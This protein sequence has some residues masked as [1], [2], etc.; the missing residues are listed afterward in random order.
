VAEI[1]EKQAEFYNNRINSNVMAGDQ[2]GVIQAGK[3][4]DFKTLGLPVGI[5]AAN[6]ATFEVIDGVGFLP[7]EG[8][9][10]P[11]S[12]IFS[13]LFGGFAGLDI[14]TRDFK[15]MLGRSDIHTIV[16]EIDSPGGSA[17]G[18]QQ[19]A[20][21]IF[22]SRSVKPIISVTSGT[23]ASA[24]MWIGAA[25]H[26]VL[27]TGDV[28]VVGSIGTVTTHTDISEFNKMMGIKQTEVAAGEFKRVPSSLEPLSEK[29]REVLQDQVNRVN[30][31]FVNGIASF[32]GVPVNT[33]NKKMGNGKIF[34][35]TQAIDAG[36][37]DE[38][39]TVESF[40]G[41][42]TDSA[43]SLRF[44]NKK[45]SNFNIFLGGAKMTVMEQLAKL[46]EENVDLYN[47]IIERGKAIAKASLDQDLAD[48]KAAEY[49]R[50]VED[51]KLEGKNDGAV[52]ERE[53]ITSI[54]SFATSSNMAMIEGFIADGKTTAPEAAVEILKAQKESNANHLQ[55]LENNAPKPIGADIV[56]PD[57]VDGSEKGLKQLVA[58]YMADNKGVTK[59]KA[60]IAC[61][62]LYPNA[63]N[64]FVQEVKKSA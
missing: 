44:I 26:K 52:A 38:K 12:D 19:F 18:I 5:N 30:D 40:L 20:N 2:K 1:Y 4:A 3:E 24:A 32:R 31:A 39:I 14:L 46:Q 50:G 48:A 56:N 34:I 28:T 21:L 36:L 22:E 27:I 62:K 55:A 9:I 59:G 10:I 51:G 6:E 45:D 57:N 42:V 63:K 61:S 33:V 58:E 8:V 54:R 60:I 13:L 25:A 64:D 43:S 49:A 7:I 16:L 35:G 47:A 11:K 29:G 41:I 53:R 17:F 15:E 23:M 37:V